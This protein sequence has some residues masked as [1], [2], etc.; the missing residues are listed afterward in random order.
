[1]VLVVEP[2]CP[3]AAFKLQAEARQLAVAAVNLHFLEPDRFQADAHGGAIFWDDDAE[4]NRTGSTLHFGAIGL[5][6]LSQVAPGEQFAM[7]KEV[8]IEYDRGGWQKEWLLDRLLAGIHGDSLQQKLIV[9]NQFELGFS[10]I[11]FSPLV[12]D[13]LS[14]GGQMHRGRLAGLFGA[15]VLAQFRVDGASSGGL[16]DI[17][18]LSRD[19]LAIDQDCEG[20]GI[21]RLSRR[22]FGS[23]PCGRS[24][25]NMPVMN[26]PIN[27]ISLLLCAPT[28]AQ[29][30]SDLGRDGVN[31][32]A[33]GIHMKPCFHIERAAGFIQL[34]E[35]VLALH[36]WT[37]IVPLLTT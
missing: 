26:F 1:M 6:I 32:F 12:P 37:R 23:C 4:R 27:F 33:A 5:A 18:F 22:F 34:A 13:Q 21:H 9:G 24:N 11:E 8:V 16:L 7:D 10:R 17:E 30:R 36:Q 14:R 25:E 28:Q 15:G 35:L 19:T 3:L 2:Q 31:V 29:T 20:P